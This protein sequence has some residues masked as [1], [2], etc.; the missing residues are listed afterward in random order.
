MTRYGT[1]VATAASPGP[2]RGR[3]YQQSLPSVCLHVI[4]DGRSVRE[5]SLRPRGVRD[6]HVD[7]SD[8][9]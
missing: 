7:L 1:W 8:L 3:A 5:A 2:C 9:D 6:G 4:S